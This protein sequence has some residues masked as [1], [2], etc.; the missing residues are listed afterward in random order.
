INSM[1]IHNSTKLLSEFLHILVNNL[2]A[3]GAYTIIFSMEEY[4]SEEITNMMNLV[5]DETITAAEV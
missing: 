2:R 1:A 4:E 3:K 5:C